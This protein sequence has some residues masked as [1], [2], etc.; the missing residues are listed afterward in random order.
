M[1]YVPNYRVTEKNSFT[2]NGIIKTGVLEIA[3]KKSEKG[4]SRPKSWRREMKESSS[5]AII[6]IPTG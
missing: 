1:L 2:K 5:L 3:G 4:S 6:D